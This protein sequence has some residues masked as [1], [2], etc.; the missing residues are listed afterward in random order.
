M[1]VFSEHLLAAPPPL[2]GFPRISNA[3]ISTRPGPLPCSRY[4]QGEGLWHFLG[5][6]RGYSGKKRLPGL[7]WQEKNKG[8]TLSRGRRH[9]TYLSPTQHTSRHLPE[10]RPFLGGKRRLSAA[11]QELPLYPSL[12]KDPRHQSSLSSGDQSPWR[13]EPL[14]AAGRRG[15][16]SISEQSNDPSPQKLRV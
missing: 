2:K 13:R 4:L 10:W 7:W 9:P 16:V 11:D 15:K 3:R 8:G 1:G 6:G 5:R 12:L 14:L